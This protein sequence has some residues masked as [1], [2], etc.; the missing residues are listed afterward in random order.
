MRESLTIHLDTLSS[1]QSVIKKGG[2]SLLDS[3]LRMKYKYEK[4]LWIIRW[5]A[6]YEESN[7]NEA[8][9]EHSVWLS[10]KFR[11][12]HFF[13]I[14]E[15]SRRAACCFFS[16]PS[17]NAWA[18]S[19]FTLNSLS[20]SSVSFASRVIIS[21]C[22]AFCCAPRQTRENQRAATTR[23]RRDGHH[24]RGPP[25]GLRWLT[26]SGGGGMCDWKEDGNLNVYLKYIQKEVTV[27]L[28]CAGFYNSPFSISHVR[29]MF[30][31]L[32][33]A[34]CTTVVFFFLFWINVL[35]RYTDANES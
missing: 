11:F 15:I 16:L 10:S 33:T 5:K 26:Y 32:V 9:M 8:C 7:L 23:G 21:A 1:L 25:V 30:L 22:S 18:P 20:D 34:Q 13:R 35:F 17:E 24:A 12:L 2:K 31:P 3:P 14:W 28:S 4:L 27:S 29:K 19:V 6:V